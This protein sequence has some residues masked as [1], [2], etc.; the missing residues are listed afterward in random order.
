MSFK[1]NL[2][3]MAHD[4]DINRNAT[5][6]NII[7]YLQETVDR[8]LKSA[9]PS[10]EDLLKQHL[11][12]VVSKTAVKIYKPFEEYSKITVET[13]AT[14]GRSAA[15]M[16]N[17]RVTSNDQIIA[18]ALMTWALLDTK[19]HRLLRGSEFDVSSYG[20][21]PL[22]EIDMPTRFRIPKDAPLEKCGEKKVMYSDIDRNL[23]MNNVKYFD[24]LFDYIPNREKVYMTSVMMNY[25]KEAGYEKNIEI[26]S[27]P[28]EITQEGETVYCFVTKIDGQTNVEARF[29]VKEI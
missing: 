28:P 8:N 18:E 5:P 16:R 29:T 1:M 15:F 20:T 19:N 6:S 14:E 9:K 4:I 22:L 7:K 26:F 10:Y 27:T 17:Y 13:W 23:H 24:M 25:V 11:S 3:V 21:G 12:F 2:E